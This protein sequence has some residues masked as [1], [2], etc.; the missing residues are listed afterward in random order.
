MIALL[1]GLG[2]V[3]GAVIASVL[4]GFTEA[5]TAK[6]FGTGTTLFAQYVL[7]F[8]VL[9]V[10]PRGIGGLLSEVRVSTQ[11]SQRSGDPCVRLR[12][13]CEGPQERTA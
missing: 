10:R 2:S 6:Y 3:P 8:A 13:P 5:L 4:V 1:G 12:T 11:R 9:I 7:V